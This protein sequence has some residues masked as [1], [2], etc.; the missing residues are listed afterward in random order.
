MCF[1]DL[2]R[3][4]PTLLLTHGVLHKI[5]SE[6]V[7]YANASVTLDTYSHV[8]TDLGEAAAKAIEDALGERNYACG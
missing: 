1:L 7:G 5:V 2:R 6:M 8:M 3:T 4:R